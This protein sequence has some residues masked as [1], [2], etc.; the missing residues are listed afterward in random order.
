MRAASRQRRSGITGATLAL[1][2]ALA[3]LSHASVTLA[4]TSF[5]ANVQRDAEGAVIRGDVSA[6]RLALI[7]TGDQFGES[8][9][10]ILET[11]A[12]R[13]I[14]AAFFLTGGFVSQDSLRP[15]INRM[16]EEGHYVG[17][18]SNS[19]PL[20]ASWENRR[21]TLVTPEFFRVDLQK[22]VEALR[23]VRALSRGTPILFVPPYEWYN[24]EQVAWSGDMG[25]GLINFTPGSGSNRD[26]AREEDR[27]FVP[28]SKI[29]EEILAY[30]QEDPHGLNG[31]LLLLHLGSGRGD[32]FHPRLGALCDALTRRGYEFARADK[33]LLAPQS[34]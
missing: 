14:Q 9:E 26:Y 16:I 13:R 20:Y 33:L 34:E 3:T 7:F 32:P 31:F 17:P 22:N 6:K 15:A 23:G 10:P 12:E 24:S 29:L 25:V 21:Q 5:A 19:H 18:H 28:S 4:E 30:E 8:A 11:L 2:V 27:A 1:V